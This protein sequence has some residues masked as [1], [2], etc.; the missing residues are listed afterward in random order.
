MNEEYKL[1]FTKQELTY[2]AEFIDSEHSKQLVNERIHN[3]P[4]EENL[5]SVILKIKN[6]IKGE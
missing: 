4:V 1:L 5:K 2:L 3:I 6:A